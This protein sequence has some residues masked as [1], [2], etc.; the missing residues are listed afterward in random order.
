MAVGYRVHSIRSLGRVITVMVPVAGGRAEWRTRAMTR[1]RSAGTAA[2]VLLAASV[3]AQPISVLRLDFVREVTDAD[4]NQTVIEQGHHFI[5]DDGAYLMDKVSNGERI[6]EI[7]HPANGERVVVNHDL[8]LAVRGPL[9]GN[10]P[11]PATQALT[12]QPVMPSPP[13]MPS[14]PGA[15]RPHLG[16]LRFPVP[17]VD[18]LG[19]RVIGALMATGS[20][21][22]IPPSAY[23][24]EQ[25]IET[26]IWAHAAARKPVVLEKSVTGPLGVDALRVTGA[27]RIL[28]SPAVFQPPP[29][30]VERDFRQPPGWRPPPVPEPERRSA[31]PGRR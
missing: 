18:S 11:I 3:E 7:W 25:V 31:W 19:E 9:D 22:I 6:S 13:V 4:G 23:Q 8:R 28:V 14:R 12:V 1:I 24:A 20:R 10:W 30:Y 29:G 5:A 21:Q 16:Q 2:I 17:A 26:W 27:T 15:G